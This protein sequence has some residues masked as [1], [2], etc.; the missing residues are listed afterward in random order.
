MISI[1]QKEGFTNNDILYNACRNI[2]GFTRS[3]RFKVWFHKEYPPE[4][5]WVMHHVFGSFSQSL[6]TSDYFSVP[7]TPK[8]HDEAEKD[9]SNYAIKVFPLM[10]KVIEKYI[11]YTEEK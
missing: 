6:K 8:Q 11:N 9:K 3:K 1:E 2:I 7:L 10:L 5:G 4:D